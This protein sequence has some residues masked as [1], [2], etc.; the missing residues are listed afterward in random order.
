LRAPRPQDARMASADREVGP[1]VTS[2]GGGG[3]GGGEIGRGRSRSRPS[4]PTPAHASFQARRRGNLAD[5]LVKMASRGEKLPGMDDKDFLMEGDEEREG[6]LN[7]QAVAEQAKR[8][9]LRMKLAASTTNVALKADTGARLA[10]RQLQSNE[11]AVRRMAKVGLHQKKEML[12]ADR[13][14]F[15]LFTAMHCAGRWT[16]GGPPGRVE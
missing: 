15:R 8:T 10:R 14:V 5:I 11:E 2:I 6:D 13:I 9:S 7:T 3:G 12:R 16:G 4:A 1:A